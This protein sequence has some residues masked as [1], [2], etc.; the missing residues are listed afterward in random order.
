MCRFVALL[1]TH[2][3]FIMKMEIC[4]TNSKYLDGLLV[5]ADNLVD[6]FCKGDLKWNFV[7]KKGF[8]IFILFNLN[9]DCVLLV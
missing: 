4:L 7:M 1:Y 8:K 5:V 6:W 3:F 9:K 2:L